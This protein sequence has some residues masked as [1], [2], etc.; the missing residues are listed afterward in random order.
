MKVLTPIAIRA[1]VRPTWASVGLCVR[2]PNGEDGGNSRCRVLAR[3]GKIVWR[4]TEVR[5]TRF[6]RPIVRQCLGYAH[7]RGG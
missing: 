5:L 3:K 6:G 2:R 4:N 7:G 1:L